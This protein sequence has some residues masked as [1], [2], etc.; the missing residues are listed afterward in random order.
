MKLNYK[1]LV[2]GFFYSKHKIKKYNILGDKMIKKISI[3]RF[4]IYTL[5]LL[6]SIL[7][8]SFP[9]ELKQPINKEFEKRN[10][11]LIDTN[12]LVSLTTIKKESDDIYKQVEQTIKCLTKNNKCNEDLNPII[13]ENTKLL[14][15]DINNNI[16]KINFSKE[17]LNYNEEEENKLYESI[18]YSLTE[19]DNIEKIILF[20]EG[21]KIDQLQYQKIRIDNY[22][23][24]NFGINKIYNINNLNNTTK[25]TIYYYNENNYYIPVTYITNN[26]DKIEMIIKELKTNSYSNNLKNII[27]Y[28][29]ELIN[30]ELNE[31]SLTINFNSLLLNSIVDGKLK[32]EVKYALLYSLKDSLNIKELIIDINFNEIER[33]GLA[34]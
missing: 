25:T 8:Y 32:E 5:L 3:R 11:Y 33:F 31:D 18:I 1:I 28:E 30:Y 27:D 13:P 4:F 9:K 10:I 34:K 23:D 22:L 29:V 14:D 20:I 21:N 6:L 17:F 24:R 19:I 2:K 26:D 16:L 7:L 15:Y 12:N